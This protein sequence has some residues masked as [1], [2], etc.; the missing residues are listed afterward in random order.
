[1][2]LP[3]TQSTVLDAVN[4]ILTMSGNNPVSSL[5]KDRTDVVSKAEDALHWASREVQ[6]FG[7]RG[8]SEKC[9]PLKPNIDKRIPLASNILKVSNPSIRCVQRGSYLFNTSVSPGTDKFT[10]TVYADVIF[11]LPFEQLSQTAKTYIMIK[12]AR[13]FQA[14]IKS[15][16]VIHQ[17]TEL[18]EYMAQ[19]ALFDEEINDEN[20]FTASDT[21]WVYH[22]RR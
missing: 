12:A 16:E 14:K 11:F 8:N 13:Q 1:M 21:L 3:L 2:A 7:L 22:Y 19:A 10:E 17:L 20:I 9:Y 6:S 18:D 15:S 5:S 4:F